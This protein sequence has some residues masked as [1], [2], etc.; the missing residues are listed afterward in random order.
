MK[1]LTW[2]SFAFLVI[3]IS[4]A[5]VV[6]SAAVDPTL[7]Q[8]VIAT[9]AFPGATAGNAIQ[10]TAILNGATNDATGT[11]AFTVYGPDD[12][13]CSGQPQFPA[14]VAAGS[15]PVAGNGFYNSTPVAFSA[16][17]T[18]R[19]VVTYT[20]DLKNN[21]ASSPCNAPGE[22]S[23]ITQGWSALITLATA[24]A[25]VGGTIQDSASTAFENGTAT[26][27]IT[28][29]VYG[30]EDPTC[31]GAGTAA[32]TV[33]GPFVDFGTYAS[34]A[35]PVTTPGI[36]RW[37]ASYSGNLTTKS[38]TTACNEPG[39]IS[40]VGGTPPATKADPTVTTEIHKEPGHL[41]VTSVPAG[42]KVHDKATVSG[43]A[44]MPTG[45]VDFTFYASGNCSGTGTAA[46]SLTLS[47]GDADPSTS[48]GPL[49]AGSY[50]F[51]ARYSGNDKYKAKDG[52]CESL[53]VTAQ[54]PPPCGPGQEDRGRGQAADEHGGNG[55]D[56]NFDECDDN[57][58]ASH[59]DRDRN[60]DFQSSRHD[61]PR[62]ERTSKAST[63]PLALT[64]T[65]GF[66]AT[67]IGEGTNNG[68]PVT[69]T[70]IVTDLG[71]G[72]GTD[73]FSLTLRDA[74]GIIYARTGVLRSGDIVVG[75]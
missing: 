40:V 24:T 71:L 22:T 65:L 73:I 27:T 36:Y 60:V 6:P 16:P 5:M 9:S 31:S 42:S 32:G 53:T 64:P 23:L 19:W 44:G 4:A 7:A 57:H 58:Q 41:A 66:K 18:Y 43:S 21:P 20:G 47:N 67:T 54:R 13:L 35:V 38:F 70:L 3:S 63:N 1:A 45:T 55:G 29:T 61:P 28:F 14:P 39:E 8:P 30:P 72:P 68:A 34:S 12:L 74:T 2:I 69:Y 59:R 62:Y 46:G 75:P 15:F 10:D 37:I 49:W 11:I 50:S 17:G 52:S 26:G 33:N 51:R 56:F 25:P 48:Q